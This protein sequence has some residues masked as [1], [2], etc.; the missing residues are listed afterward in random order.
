MPRL[1]AL[2]WKRKGIKLYQQYIKNHGRPDVIHVHSMLN[3]GLVATEI[4][5][6]HNI[7]YVI[8][9]HSSSF[10][11][12]LVTDR[13]RFAANDIASKASARFAVS[14][15]FS[16]LL[17]EFLGSECGDWEVMPNIVNDM[18][19]DGYSKNHVKEEFTF[20]N[21]C[22]LTENKRVD[23]LLEGF[24]RS[25][26]GKENVKLRIGGEGPE[27]EPLMELAETLKIAAQVT[28]LGMLTRA[29]VS[30]EMERMDAFVLSS[31]YETFGV[32]IVEALAKGKPVI[33]TRCGGPE[34]IVREEDGFLVPV[35]DVLAMAE[36]MEIL[37]QNYSSFESEKI[38]LACKARYS[39]SAIAQRLVEVYKSVMKNKSAVPL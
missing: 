19:F 24:A 22:L 32:V 3:A 9:E 2:W 7:P 39:E 16:D 29:Q 35:N 10:A 15:P 27:R 34:D 21:V 36:A 8:T 25:F 26:A 33:A 37:H 4:E 28:F 1:A 18:F 12:K 20:L 6:A 23:V 14:E 17:S 13:Q 30:E 38:R 31:E 11:R 5:R